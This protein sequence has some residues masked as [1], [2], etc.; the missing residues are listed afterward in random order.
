MRLFV[1]IQLSDEV[2]S[3]L[4]AMQ[5]TLRR[6]CDGVRWTRPEQLHLTLKFLGEVLDAEVSGVAE[7]VERAAGRAKRFEISL[8]GSG[9]F[10]PQG[11]VRIVWVGVE[12]DSGELARCAQA[13]ETELER[14]GFARERRP[15][16]PHITIGR[17]REARS[18]GRTRS[19]TEAHAL[20]PVE[21][22]VRA[23]API[24]IRAC[25]DEARRCD[26]LGSALPD[27]PWPNGAG[28]T[29]PTTFR[30]TA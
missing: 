1:A 9:C 21:Q 14:I 17:V 18:K 23:E 16:S 15:F 11:P 27:L 8:N 24:R 3:A 30:T 29:L 12:E 28:W 25:F 5:H 10:P 2:R 4:M 26:R 22:A 7:A 20:R 19:A 6:R 13:M